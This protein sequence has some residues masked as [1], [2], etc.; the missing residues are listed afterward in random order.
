VQRHCV[1]N[2]THLMIK[3]QLV[4]ASLLFLNGQEEVLCFVKLSKR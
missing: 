4:K 3:I 2:L 1:R